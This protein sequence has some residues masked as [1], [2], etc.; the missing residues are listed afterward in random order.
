LSL[1]RSTR[2]FR[3]EAVVSGRSLFT[4]SGYGPVSAGAGS[5]PS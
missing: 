3:S 1:R 5:S 2:V 4:G